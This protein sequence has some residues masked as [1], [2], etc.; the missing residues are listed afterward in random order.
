VF[1]GEYG[2][3]KGANSSN[4]EP[5]VRAF[6]QKVMPWGAPFLLFWELYNNEPGQRYWLV[7]DTGLRTPCYALHRRFANDARLEV[8]RFKERNGRIPTEAEFSGLAE[9]LLNR[10]STAP[11]PLEIRNGPGTDARGN[12]VTV[13]GFLDQG[14][15]G[16]EI[17]RG[18]VY[19]GPADGGTNAGAWAERTSMGRKT[20]F[21]TTVFSANL[22]NLVAG[23]N[24]FR[25]FASNA[26]AQ[27][28]APASSTLVRTS[29]AA[30]K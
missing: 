7:D 24:Y 21:N 8:A 20:N 14:L 13:T 18:W 27:A 1:I 2:W 16:D 22:A 6:W 12:T 9:R 23:T 3:G 4:Q 11:V 10:P 17:A 30:T 19:W 25:F 5:V 29:P 28:W 26:T 15:Y